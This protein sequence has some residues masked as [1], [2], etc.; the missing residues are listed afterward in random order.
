MALLGLRRNI[1]PREGPLDAGGSRSHHGIGKIF[2]V[3]LFIGVLFFETGSPYV[4]QAGLE[5]TM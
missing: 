3:A 5:F 2:P 1:L 4:A